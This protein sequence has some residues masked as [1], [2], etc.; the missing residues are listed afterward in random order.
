VAGIEPGPRDLVLG[1]E[2][3]PAINRMQ[4]PKPLLMVE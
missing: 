1:D 3:K 2:F 4:V